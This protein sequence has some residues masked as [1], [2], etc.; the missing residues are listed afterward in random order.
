VF[1]SLT[2]V[3]TEKRSA[4]FSEIPWNNECKFITECTVVSTNAV[5]V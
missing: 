3:F 1:K 2:L 4:N 5:L